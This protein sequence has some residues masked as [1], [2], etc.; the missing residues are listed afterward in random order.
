LAVGIGVAGLVGMDLGS[1]NADPGQRCGAP[2]APACQHAPGQQNS[3]PQNNGPQNNGPAPAPAD[4][5][6]RGV[7]QGRQDHQPFNYNGQQ[8]QPMPAG[9]GAGWGFWFLGVWIPL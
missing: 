7:D 1:A 3:G 8:V 4:W 6:N 9:N 5:R 2:N